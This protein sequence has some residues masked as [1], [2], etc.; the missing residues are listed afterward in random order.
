MNAGTRPIDHH[1]Q[2]QSILRSATKIPPQCIRVPSAL[3]QIPKLVHHAFMPQHRFAK[4]QSK[5]HLVYQRFHCA[6]PSARPRKIRVRPSPEVAVTVSA[7]VSLHSESQRLP[8]KR[9]PIQ[10][11]PPR[12]KRVR[13]RRPRKSDPPLVAHRET[14]RR[15]VM[16]VPR[17]RV[18]V[19]LQGSAARALVNSVVAHLEMKRILPAPAKLQS[20]QRESLNEALRLPLRRKPR[21]PN[22]YRHPA[23]IACATAPPRIHQQISKPPSPAPIGQSQPNKPDF[24]PSPHRQRR[25]HFIQRFHKPI[26][27]G[28]NTRYNVRRVPGKSWQAWRFAEKR[29]CAGFGK[30]TTAQVAEK[31]RVET[32]LAPSQTAEEIR[33]TQD[34]GKGTTFSRAVSREDVPAL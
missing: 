1:V 33:F 16:Q 25:I 27:L 32:G 7:V 6:R 14:K 24:I 8:G 10:R 15:T 5:G 19:N 29:R 17:D 12:K 34:F 4:H 22:L 20:L 28:P 11:N 30:G 21:S 18:T 26:L 23:R 9:P 2:P 13:M 31:T 3:L